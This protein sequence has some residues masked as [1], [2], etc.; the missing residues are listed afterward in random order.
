MNPWL[1]TTYT[2]NLDGLLESR[3]A[4]AGL[5]FEFPDRSTLNFSW[6]ERF[7][8]LV[9]PFVVNPGTTIP[10]G[11]YRFGEGS[12]RYSSSQGRALSVN[13]GVSGGGFYD[14][15]R[16]TLTGGMRWQPDRHLVLDVDA[17]RNAIQ[18]QGTSFTADLYSARVQ[19]ALTTQFN[20]STYVQYNTA[21]DEVVSNVRA[22]FIHAPL[23]NLFL[24]YTE[25]RS[26][27]GGSVLER[28]LTV[29]VTRLLLF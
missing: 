12:A 6:T 24:L 25:R 16:A 8:R 18:A 17:N 9:N 26:A 22:D 13:A 1:E 15:T 23:S 19:Y 21:V 29:K 20:V 14:G 10:V 5:A 7:E 28:F 3:E 4:L 2:T 11:A 27:N